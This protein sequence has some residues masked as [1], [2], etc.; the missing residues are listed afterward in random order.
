MSSAYDNLLSANAR[1]TG[2]PFA[3]LKAMVATESDFNPNAVRVEAAINDKSIGL[4]QILVGTARTIVPGITEAQLFVPAN[5]LMIGSRYLAQQVSRYGGD[6]WKGV[7]AYNYGSAK[8]AVTPTTVCLA[9]DARGVCIK[10][11]TALPG[12]FYNQ[13]YV[14]KVRDRTSGYGFD[15]VSGDGSS[16]GRDGSV[17]PLIVLGII[18]IAGFLLTR[19]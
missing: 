7:A 9:R 4:M 14:D 12:Q 10:S 16:T 13:P 19:R 15:D 5:N 6:I 8:V 18:A 11:F 17:S 3:L 2:L 1:D